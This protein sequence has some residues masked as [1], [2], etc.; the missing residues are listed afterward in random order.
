MTE[1][2]NY[3]FPDSSPEQPQDDTLLSSKLRS[4]NSRIGFSVLLLTAV[5]FGATLLLALVFSFIDA[6]SGT[7]LVLFLN[8]YMFAFNEVLAAL[9]V[10]FAYLL[11]RSMP[12]YEPKKQS[13]SVGSFLVLLCI[14]FG[15]TYMGSILSSILTGIWNALTGRTVSDDIGELLTGTDFLQTFLFVAIVGPIIEEL[16]FRKILIDRLR[17]YG[18]KVAILVSSVLFGLFHMNISQIFYTFGLGLLFGYLYCRTGKVWLPIL[19]H[20]LYNLFSGV[21][22]AAIQTELLSFANNLYGASVEELQELFANLTAD[23]TL[24]LTVIFFCCIYILAMFVFS[25]VGIVLFFVRMKKAKLEKGEVPLPAKGTLGAIVLNPGFIL[26]ALFT[27][28]VMVLSMC[29]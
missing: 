20:G 6:W 21:I 8:R 23:D 19:L 24:Y 14:C 27:L 12:K 13:I 10:F 28:S 25:V 2:Q 3:L 15:I 16:F 22:N 29:L 9:A 4:D 5:F 18:D 17:G 7:S 11:I 26:A 1:D